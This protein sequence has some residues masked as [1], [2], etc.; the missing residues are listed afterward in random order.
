[1]YHVAGRGLAFLL[2]VLGN[3]QSKGVPCMVGGAEPEEQHEERRS[4]PEAPARIWV[5]NQGAGH[6]QVLRI[7]AG[8]GQ[9]GEAMWVDEQ[10]RTD[11]CA[12]LESPGFEI[13]HCK[14]K[15]KEFGRY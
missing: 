7:C 11:G 9:E 15:L 8:L 5:S 13:L 6:L 1:M 3:H 10:G 12:G 14:V 2:Q 4:G